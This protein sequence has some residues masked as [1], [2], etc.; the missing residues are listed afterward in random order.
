MRFVA[1]CAQAPRTRT[2]VQAEAEAAEAAAAEAEALR[3][4]PIPFY[5]QRQLRE[6]NSEDWRVKTLRFFNVDFGIAAASHSAR[7]LPRTLG[8]EP[9]DEQPDL[10][11]RGARNA[12]TKPH[13]PQKQGSLSERSSR[14]GRPP[15]LLRCVACRWP[16]SHRVCGG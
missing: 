2:R 9:T 14:T 16:A 15:R 5:V 8:Q 6:S 10:A 12:T 1:A 11:P 7:G 4:D 3:E 13:P